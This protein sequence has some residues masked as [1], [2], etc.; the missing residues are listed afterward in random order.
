MEQEDRNDS[1]IQAIEQAANATFPGT[2]IF[3]RDV[4]LPEALAAKYSDG[5][6]LREKAFTDASCRVMGMVTSHRYAIISNH[7]ADI[8]AFEHGTNWG[9]CIAQSGSHF[10]VLGQYSF[11]EKTMVVLLH[12]PDDDQWKLFQN[13]H[14]NIEDQLLQTCIE[15]FEAKCKGVVVPELTTPEWLDRCSFPL[16]MD[17]NGNLW[18]L[19]EN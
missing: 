16:G 5:L 3:V 4:N 6:I 8:S 15:R 12:L 14:F 18:E 19:E 13:N 1:Y 10:K 11:S 17:D 7:M 9:L 2:Q